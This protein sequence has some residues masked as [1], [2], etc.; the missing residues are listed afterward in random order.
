MILLFDNINYCRH[1]KY[2]NTVQTLEAKLINRILEDS[3]ISKLAKIFR[4]EIKELNR[5]TNGFE[6]V[7]SILYYLVL[8]LESNDYDTT[9]IIN[10]L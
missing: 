10:K 4:E 2:Y 7:L 8:Y 1:K 6:I 9:I 3:M 5:S